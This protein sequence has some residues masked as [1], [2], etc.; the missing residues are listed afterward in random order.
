VADG[1]ITGQ[2]PRAIDPHIAQEIQLC[3]DVLSLAKRMTRER[4]LRNKI[5]DG[6]DFA[7][8]VWD[9]LLDLYV[10]HSEGRWV[11]VSSLCIAS[12]VPTSTA[13]RKITKMEETGQL[14]R[15]LDPADK[16]RAYIALSD[17]V[18]LKMDKFLTAIVLGDRR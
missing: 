2:H 15:H 10:A 6:I 13:L 12:G 5:V 4:R 3:A 1:I 9:M 14:C 7:E 8:P 11:S 17:D 18:R 16:R